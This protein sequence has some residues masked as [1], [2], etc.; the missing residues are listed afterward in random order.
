MFKLLILSLSLAGCVT[1]PEKKTDEPYPLELKLYSQIEA[2]DLA[3]AEQTKAT[4]GAS[5]GFILSKRVRHLSNYGASIK[6]LRSVER[7]KQDAAAF[8]DNGINL[9]TGNSLLKELANLSTPPSALQSL[10]E[11]IPGV[12]VAASESLKPIEAQVRQRVATIKE[13][14]AAEKRRKE[15]A[16][17][18][19]YEAS[20][21]ENEARLA[22][23]EKE[24]QERIAAAKAKREKCGADY[25]KPRIGMAI[26]RAKE[27]VAPLRLDSQINRADGVLSTYTARG[28][29]VHVMDGVI[30]SWG[31]LPGY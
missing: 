17:Q 20:Q 26:E 31:K 12:V 2:G 25:L 6:Y 24:R 22:K 4:L 13:N 10:P 19:R 5:R 3:G 28:V 14:Q 9:Y 30:V 8:A 11:P 18:A 15:A 1:L 29:Y 16:Y 23:L 7:A 21:R 27:C